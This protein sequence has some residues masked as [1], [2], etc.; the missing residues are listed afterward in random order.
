[1]APRANVHFPTILTSFYGGV[2]TKMS[3]IKVDVECGQ[4]WEVCP[5]SNHAMVVIK[6]W[7]K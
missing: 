5:V 2:S 6:M 1:M 7:E 3:A 4:V